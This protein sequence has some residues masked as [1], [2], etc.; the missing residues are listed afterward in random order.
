MYLKYLDSSYI[1]EDGKISSFKTYMDKQVS[2]WQKV[3]D[4]LGLSVRLVVGYDEDDLLSNLVEIL[5]KNEDE[6]LEQNWNEGLVESI[7]T[8]EVRGYAGKVVGY[9]AKIYNN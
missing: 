2:Y 4:N 7:D 5:G 8:F 3:G 1:E 6:I 9:Y